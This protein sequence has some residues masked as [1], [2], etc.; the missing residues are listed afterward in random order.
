MLRCKTFP[1]PGLPTLVITRRA[2]QL[3][4][5]NVLLVNE[6]VRAQ[7]THVHQMLFRQEVTRTRVLYRSPTS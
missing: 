5:M 1:C 3:D 7:V 4:T 2:N 6:Q